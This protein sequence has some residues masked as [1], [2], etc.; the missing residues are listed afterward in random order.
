MVEK[1]VLVLS[2]QNSFLIGSFTAA[3][4]TMEAYQENPYNFFP[5]AMLGCYIV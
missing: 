2:M 5:A 1:M 3:D 4:S